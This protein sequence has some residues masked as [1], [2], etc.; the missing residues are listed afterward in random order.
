M[1]CT[2][3]HSLFEIQTP[4]ISFFPRLFLVLL[5]R[6]GVNLIQASAK[7]VQ[8][9][10]ACLAWKKGIVLFTENLVLPCGGVSKPRPGVNLMQA[11]AKSLQVVGEKYK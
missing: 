1:T 6:P 5:P 10:I 9:A 7:S 11:G 8:V 3:S 2:W 4:Q